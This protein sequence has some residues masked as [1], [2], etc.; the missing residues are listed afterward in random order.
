MPV[1]LVGNKLDLSNAGKRQI[2]GREVMAD[3]VDSGE[4]LEYKET[5]AV[6]MKGVESLFISIAE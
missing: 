5:S 3:W 4:A 1:I 6:T 2:E